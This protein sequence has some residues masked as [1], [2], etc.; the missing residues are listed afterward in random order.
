[1]SLVLKNCSQFAQHDFGFCTHSVLTL[2][3]GTQ[4]LPILQDGDADDTGAVLA[5]EW[6]FDRQL[7]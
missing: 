5:P 6:Q 3:L 4:A 7:V 1:M 2:L